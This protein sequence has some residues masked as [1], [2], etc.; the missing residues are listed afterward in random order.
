MHAWEGAG[1]ERRVLVVTV[2]EVGETTNPW[3]DCGTHSGL[4]KTGA[5]VIL[6]LEEGLGELEV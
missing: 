3:V 5:E 1:K 6:M 2:N 4:G